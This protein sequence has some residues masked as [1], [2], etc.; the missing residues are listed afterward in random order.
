VF[1]SNNGINPLGADALFFYI[2]LDSLLNLLIVLRWLLRLD[3][4]NP[5]C[6]ELE[7]INAFG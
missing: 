5:S 3:A 4:F 7:A 2:L 6:E 1:I